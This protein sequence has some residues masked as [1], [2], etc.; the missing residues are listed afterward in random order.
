MRRLRAALALIT[1]LAL[2]AGPARALDPA[3]FQAVEAMVAKTY[4][5]VEHVTT[6]DVERLRQSGDAVLLLDVREMSEFRVSRIPGAVRVDP[7]AWTRT[8]MA[9]IG[10]DARGRTVVLY[11]SVGVRS[12]KLAGRAQKALREAGAVRVVNLMGGI[13]RWHNEMRTLENDAGQTGDVHPYDARW[14]RLLSRQHLARE[15]PH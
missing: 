6:L 10:A 15:M 1:A 3:E 8:L 5:D 12:A 13:F 14:G 11:C 9:G 7:G 2:L 4:P